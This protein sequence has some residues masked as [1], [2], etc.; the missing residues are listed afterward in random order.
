MSRP[1]GV[2]LLEPCTVGRWL[3]SVAVAACL[4]IATAAAGAAQTPGQFRLQEATIAAIQQAIE[5]K[6]IT[7]V[8]LVELYLK[9]IKAYNGTC[10]SEP[11]GMLG[12]ITTIPQAGQIN[13]LSTLNLRPAT[14]TAWGFDARKARSLTDRVD[15]SR[16][17]CR[18]RSKWPRRRTGSSSRPAGSSAR[19]TAS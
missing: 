8:S 5:T 13:A 18:T 9:R 15:A 17:T 3:C 4:V 16:A 12:P 10:V 1:V 19:C 11:E 7:T 6:Q 2:G 14:R